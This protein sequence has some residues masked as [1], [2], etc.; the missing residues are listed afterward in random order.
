MSNFLKDLEQE[1]SGSIAIK[2][3]IN[4]LDDNMGLTKEGLGFFPGMKREEQLSYVTRNGVETFITGLD[5]F[6]PSVTTIEN[7]DRREAKIKRIRETV[8]HLEKVLAQNIIDVKD[9]EFWNKVTLL[10]PTNKEFWSKIKIN[11]G[12]KGMHLDPLNN[13]DDL[14]IM[15]AIE[16][17]GFSS[18]AKSYEDALNAP[19]P[20]KFFLDKEIATV[21]VKAKGKIA[22]NKAF[23]LLDE[24]FEEGGNKLMY[25][26]KVVDIYPSKYK[27][28]TPRALIYDAMDEFIDGRSF[29]KNKDRAVKNFTEVANMDMEELK[30]RAILKDAM[31]FKKVQ[32]K[33]DGLLYHS[34]TNSMM[35]RNIE[36][37]VE[38]VKN[39]L[40]KDIVDYLIDDVEKLW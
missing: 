6:S 15:L 26:A 18:V 17:G 39:P 9:P 2:T 14:I 29:E 33:A 28:K 30:I 20:P 11:I 22:K 34:K 32:L 23:A 8:A 10:K 5:E 25:V 40:N 4:G 13:P 24:I 7:K 16:E 31:H 12:N 1:A 37:A 21:D 19:K 36:D 3:F 38:F 35:G 27:I